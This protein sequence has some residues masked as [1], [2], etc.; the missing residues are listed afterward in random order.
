MPYGSRARNSERS[1]ASQSASANMPRSFI[2][3]ASRFA[4]QNIASSTS[5]SDCVWKR[6]PARFEL[7][8]QLAIVVDLAV[9]DDRVAAIGAEHRLMAVLGDVDDREAAVAE[10]EPAVR[11]VP[12]A[13]VVRSAHAHRVAR[14]PQLLPI[15]R[16]APSRRNA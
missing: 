11:R 15:R 16:E 13:R 7:R 14:A 6:Q 8:A 5:V 3:I 4:S 10:G 9:E 2:S 12:L 1:R